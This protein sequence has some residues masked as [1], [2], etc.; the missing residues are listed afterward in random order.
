MSKEK[1][2][3]ISSPRAVKR[4]NQLVKAKGLQQIKEPRTGTSEFR[5]ILNRKTKFLPSWSI[6]CP[7]LK[8]LNSPDLK[9]FLS[10]FTVLLKSSA[11]SICVPTSF[12]EFIYKKSDFSK[13]GGSIAPFSS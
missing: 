10:H 5:S 1:S 13:P 7:E 11:F 9:C 6:R 12:P 8:L 3:V 2:G 4:T